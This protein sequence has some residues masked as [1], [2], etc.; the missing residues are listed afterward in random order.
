MTATICRKLFTAD[1]T[2]DLLLNLM[3]AFVLDE[4]LNPP[5]GYPLLYGVLPLPVTWKYRLPVTEH[6]CHSSEE[7]QQTIE[8]L[9]AN[10][11]VVAIF[12]NP[13]LDLISI[14]RLIVIWANPDCAEAMVYSEES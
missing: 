5:T 3:N 6:I 8:L 9:Q 13:R 14:P 10:E 2:A 4:P 12:S 1:E 11:N 7:L